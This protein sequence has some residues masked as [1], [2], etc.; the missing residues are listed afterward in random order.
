MFSCRGGQEK[1]RSFRLSQVLSTGFAE[2]HDEDELRLLATRDASVRRDRSSSSRM[3][4]DQRCSNILQHFASVYNSDRRRN[5]HRSAL[6]H[7]ICGL[8]LLP[9]P[10]TLPLPL[11]TAAFSLIV[12][13]TLSLGLPRSTFINIYN[14]VRS[15]TTLVSA[16]IWDIRTLIKCFS[17]SRI[18]PG[19]S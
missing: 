1:A 4:S 7:F 18:W 19:S 9:L 5:A 11:Q 8:Q 12:L 10:L 2:C 3:T 16:Q 15:S 13:I 14:S 6:T 17:V